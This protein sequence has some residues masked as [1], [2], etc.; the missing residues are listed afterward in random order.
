MDRGAADARARSRTVR[1]DR[2]LA[3]AT[4]ADLLAGRLEATLP[5][6]RCAGRPG[7]GEILVRTCDGW[8]VSVRMGAEAG[9]VD[10]IDVIGPAKKALWHAGTGPVRSGPECD[11]RVSPV[12]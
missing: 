5:A 2:D 6:S 8:A 10:F 9:E 12:S 7:E 4:I 3:R 11:R 1:S